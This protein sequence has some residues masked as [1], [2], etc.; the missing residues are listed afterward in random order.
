MYTNLLD[1]IKDVQT[2]VEKRGEQEVERL[3]ERDTSQMCC[4]GGTACLNLAN[5]NVP[6]CYDH[7][8][9]D[10]FL[11]SGAFGTLDSGA[12]KAP[13]GSIANLINGSFSVAGGS[14]TGAIY[15]SSSTLNT[16]TLAIPTPYTSAGVGSAI[17]ASALGGE[18]TFTFTITIA[19]T[20]LQGTTLAPTTISVGGS[21]STAPGTTVA[22]S[23]VTPVTSVVTSA[24]TAGGS[25][26]S[27]GG[28]GQ[29]AF[30]TGVV[31]FGA[32]AGIMLA[33]VIGL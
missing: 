3:V 14:S 19:G 9:T 16:A 2:S 10:F 23:T 21:V 29:L 11:P 18:A 27:T 17:P 26:S 12:Y 33:G 6:F 4:V 30:P 8:T 20:T 31:G 24:V 22:A 32:V 28:V 13:D 15:G 7:F 25:S 5:V 1:S